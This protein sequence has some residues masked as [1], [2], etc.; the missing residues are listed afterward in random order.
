MMLHGDLHRL[1][2][3]RPDR[4]IRGR[5]DNGQETLRLR[6]GAEGE[7]D[8]GLRIIGPGSLSVRAGLSTWIAER[9]AHARLDLPGGADTEAAA[10]Y[11]GT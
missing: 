1:V 8:D 9:E 10:H 11:L 5:V 2:D 7:T 4:A 6:M 3:G